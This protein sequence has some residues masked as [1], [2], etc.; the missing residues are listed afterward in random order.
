MHMK[1]KQQHK[2]ILQCNLLVIFV[3]TR[4]HA[5]EE[6]TT[7]THIGVQSLGNICNYSLACI[8]EEHTTQTHIAV[9]RL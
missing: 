7:Q 8:Y 9:P 4:W 3:I 1:G 5:Y 2:H 6:Q